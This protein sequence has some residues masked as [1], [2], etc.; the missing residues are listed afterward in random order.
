MT[1][2]RAL[3]TLGAKPLVVV[4]AQKNAQGGWM[5]AQNELGTLSSNSSHDLLPNASHSM[6]TENEHTAA[7]SSRAINEVVHAVRTKTS[8]AG[9]AG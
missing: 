6:L 9:T 4:T 3:T 1:Q 8:L 5:A 7:Q 2:A